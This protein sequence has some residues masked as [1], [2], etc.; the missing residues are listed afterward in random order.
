MISAISEGIISVDLNSPNPFGEEDSEDI[1]LASC[2]IRCYCI[3]APD[4]F[5]NRG[6]LQLTEPEFSGETLGGEPVALPLL[7]CHPGCCHKTE[8][9]VLA[10]PWWTIS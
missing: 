10:P 1:C 2:A 3:E 9:S 5:V 6:F 8:P 4:H 7:A